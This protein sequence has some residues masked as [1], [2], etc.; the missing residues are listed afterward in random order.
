MQPSY[1][2]TLALDSVDNG[3]YGSMI[4][5]LGSVAGLFGSIPCC[6][7]CPNPYKSVSQGSVGLIS[8]FGQ[9]YKSVDPGLVK[10]N[11]YSEKIR[12]VDVKIQIA[13]V[14]RQ[15]VVTRDNVTV[16]IDSVIYYHIVNP[17]K[18][19]FGISDVRLAL[20]ERSQTTLRNVVGSRTLQ[21][22]LT[23]R[24]AVAAEIEAIV[25]DVAARWG[26]SIESIL[27]KDIVFSQE[28]QQSLSSGAQQKRIGEAKI[29][30][31]RAEVDA[32]QLMRKAADILSSPAAMQIRQLETLQAMAKSANAK[33]IFVPMNLFSGG[34]DDLA[35]PSGS[36]S[37]SGPGA[38][39]FS[40][41]GMLENLANTK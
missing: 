7:C 14:S 37:A 25:E 35:G 15:S 41:A 21:S 9:F 11:P 16:E 18:A 2:Q 30:S 3:A 22:L 1:A 10:I 17:F 36:G 40:Q 19:A 8:R 31:A 6:F 5:C 28:L 13:P 27:I 24:E 39:I 4:T 38:N 26:I 34:G 32:A 23:D 29:I 12:I 33:C 20:T